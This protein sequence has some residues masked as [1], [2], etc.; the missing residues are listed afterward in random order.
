M[1]A[2]VAKHPLVADQARVEFLYVYCTLTVLNQFSELLKGCRLVCRGFATTLIVQDAEPVKLVLQELS[3]I[4]KPAIL[5]PQYAL[6]SHLPLLERPLI[7]ADV[8]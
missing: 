1:L 6:A 7:D 2:A 8:V 5:C 3:L 4:E